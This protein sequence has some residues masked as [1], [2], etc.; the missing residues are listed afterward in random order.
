MVTLRNPQHTRECIFNAALAEF[1]LNGFAGGRI[2]NIARRA[3]VNK[4]MLYFYFGNKKNLFRCI[5]KQKLAQRALWPATAPE[6]LKE[7]LVYWFDLACRDQDW[8]RLLECEALHWTERELIAED[9]RL[10]SFNQ[11]V[12]Q[13][14]HRQAQGKLPDNY[15]PR[16]LLLAFM[17]L[18][19]FP[20][21]FPQLTRLITG[22]QVTGQKFRGQHS[23]FLASLPARFNH[24]PNPKLYE[25]GHA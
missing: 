12:D 1:A 14:R 18:T 16:Q 20:L 2:N 11:A 8:I 13:L 7:T 19:I 5:L 10:K 17:A 9:K 24:R 25:N 21:A 23:A 22:L 4:R 6:D 3:R 15:D